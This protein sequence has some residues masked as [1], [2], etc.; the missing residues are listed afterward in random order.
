MV[1]EEINKITMI[2]SEDTPDLDSP[3]KNN[4]HPLH[5]TTPHDSILE[6]DFEDSPRSND[7]DEFEDLGRDELIDKARELSFV[8]KSLLIKV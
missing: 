2:Y 8:N 7:T 4:P 5:F 6:Q 1:E 3:L